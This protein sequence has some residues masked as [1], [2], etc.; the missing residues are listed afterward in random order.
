[1]GTDIVK[2]IVGPKRKE[3]TVHKNLICAV[4]EVFKAAFDGS[5]AEGTSNEMYLPEDEP[6]SAQDLV[7]YCYRGHHMHG[8]SGQHPSDLVMLYIFC[9]KFQC[10]ELKNL[11]MDHLQDSLK[12]KDCF[13]SRP[14][15]QVIFNNTTSMEFE[16]LRRYCAAELSFRIVRTELDIAHWVTFLGEVGDL[17]FQYMRFDQSEGKKRLCGD[18]TSLLGIDPRVRI[19]GRTRGFTL[20]HFHVHAA[21]EQCNSIPSP[22]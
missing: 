14:A 13:L 21:G 5:F 17:L 12:Q 11:A 6:Q 20:C 10:N 2:L 18:N 19:S 16:P 7:S 1:M 9:D 8:L 22:K 15:I 4:S 3:I